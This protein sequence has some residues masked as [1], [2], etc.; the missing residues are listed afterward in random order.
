[1][2][3]I[4]VATT[5]KMVETVLVVII[6]S[7]PYFIVMVPSVRVEL[8]P[9]PYQSIVLTVIL[10]GNMLGCQPYEINLVSDAGLEPALLV[11]QTKVLPLTLPADLVSTGRLELPTNRLRADYSAVEL[12]TQMLVPRVRIELTYQVLH[13][14]AKPTQLSW[15]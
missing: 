3:K 5:Y 14:C 2:P 4:T 7:P 1:M 12:R 10:R 15:H 8:T 6:S 11:P 13:A 9:T